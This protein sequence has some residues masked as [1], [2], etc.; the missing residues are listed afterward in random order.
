[1]DD[2]PF[3]C[4]PIF[5]MVQ[6][7]APDADNL[8]ENLL[9]E[10]ESQTKIIQS[11]QAEISCLKQ[12]LANFD[13]TLD[14]LY[15]ARGQLNFHT[16]KLL[17]I[18]KSLDVRLNDVSS[19]I[20]SPLSTESCI[21]SVQLWDKLEGFITEWLKNPKQAQLKTYKSELIAL[22]QQ[23]EE[24]KKNYNDHLAIINRLETI[25]AQKVADFENLEREMINLYDSNASLLKLLSDKDSQLA[26]D[27]GNNYKAYFIIAVVS[28]FLYV[29][30]FAPV[31]RLF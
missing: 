31:E 5:S 19:E 16:K 26:A 6:P 15:V 23:N 11:Q 12:K 8:M 4:E 17:K 25:G 2:Q 21:Q 1:M 3:N 14:D 10:R 29:Y 9:T 7:S 18:L 13:Q 24:L 28:V 20:H 22:R 30:L 27:N